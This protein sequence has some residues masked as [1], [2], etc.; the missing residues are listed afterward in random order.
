M[1]GQGL[2]INLLIIGVIGLIV[3][4]IMVAMFAGQSKDTSDALGSCG[5]AGGVCI[6]GKAHDGYIFAFGKSCSGKD[7]DDDGNIIKGL[8]NK[9]KDA[10]EKLTFSGYKCYLPA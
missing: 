8:E 2:S 9:V 10:K 5:V 3:M 6:E 4:V 7:I 1:K